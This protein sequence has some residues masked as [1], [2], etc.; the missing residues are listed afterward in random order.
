VKL[1]LITNVEKYVY[2]GLNNDMIIVTNF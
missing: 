1:F 2:N